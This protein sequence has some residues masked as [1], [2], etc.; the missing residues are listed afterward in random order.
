[1]TDTDTDTASRRARLKDLLRHA[2]TFNRLQ[3]VAL[4]RRL[5]LELDKA[6]V[7]LDEA[8]SHHVVTIPDRLEEAKAHA[9]HVKE[10]LV[11]P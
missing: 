1:M 4:S 8:N 11:H 5:A 7:A 6:L 9:Q 3:L 2:R 10:S